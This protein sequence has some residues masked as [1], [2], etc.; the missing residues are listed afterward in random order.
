MGCRLESRTSTTRRRGPRIFG[1]QPGL[2]LN[3][4]SSTVTD[5][6]DEVVPTAPIAIPTTI[7]A[8]LIALV[9][10]L[11]LAR[12]VWVL[13]KPRRAALAPEGGAAH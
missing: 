10:V 11:V 12:V 9:I 1:L 7:V 13:L 6:L 4:F 2:L 8:G 3:L 5:T